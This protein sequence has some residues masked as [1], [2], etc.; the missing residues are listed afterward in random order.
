MQLFLASNN[1]FGT[2]SSELSTLISGK[3]IGYSCNALDGP[4]NIDFVEQRAPADMLALSAAGADVQRIDLQDYFNAKEK[5]IALL[6]KLDGIFFSGG[7]VYRLR[8]AMLLSGFDTALQQVYATGREFFYGGYS[9]GCCVLSSNLTPYTEASNPNHNTY[10]QTSNVTWEGLGYIDYTFLP[11]FASGH[12]ESE[13]INKELQFCLDNGIA[14]KTV[15]DGEV[16]I[17]KV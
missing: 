12:G 17:L 14:Y 6:S 15:Q 5:I 1:D 2:N 10:P 7:N 11:H 9:A 8:T 16:M 4:Q 3:K 13:A